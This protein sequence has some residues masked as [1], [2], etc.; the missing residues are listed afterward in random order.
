MYSCGWIHEV[1]A[2]NASDRIFDAQRHLLSI[3]VGFHKMKDMLRICT[4]VK[5]DTNGKEQRGYEV[6]R[7]CGWTDLLG[8][9][10]SR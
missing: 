1:L 8:V 9:G 7:G 6:S 3:P 10:D 2:L 4:F 5:G